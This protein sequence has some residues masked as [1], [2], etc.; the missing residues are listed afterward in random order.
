MTFLPRLGFRV[1]LRVPTAEYL[2]GPERAHDEGRGEAGGHQQHH[3]SHCFRYNA[4]GNRTGNKDDR[5]E[6]DGRN[7]VKMLVNV[8]RW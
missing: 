2:L 5:G 8:Q 4:Q 1:W 7:S 6:E 3:R